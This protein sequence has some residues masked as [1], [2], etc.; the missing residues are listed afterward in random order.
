MSPPPHACVC[1]C[2]SLSLSQHGSWNMAKSRLRRPLHSVILAGDT[3]ERL[4]RDMVDFLASENWYAQHGVP[5]KRGYLLHGT[6]GSGK[7]SFV[8]A[9][10]GHLGLNIYALSLGSAG[11]TDDAL[12]SLL[13]T[14]PPHSIVLIEDIEAAF[15]RGMGGAAD[16]P[17]PSLLTLSGLLNALDGVSSQDGCLIFLTT[18]FPQQL[19]ERLV[20]S[21]RIDVKVPFACATKEQIRRLWR[22]FYP[23]SDDAELE[24]AFVE[25]APADVLAM[26]DLQGLL[27]DHKR[28]P[29]EALRAMRELVRKLNTGNPE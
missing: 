19:P 22:S 21:G 9:V 20:R 24:N 13:L 16:A 2:V 5:W 26:A 3:S 25:A 15:S 11:L 6:P 17:S 12:Q 8:T 29:R 23:Q 18:N 4:V 10:A 7:T 1:V 28:E 27:L 14:V